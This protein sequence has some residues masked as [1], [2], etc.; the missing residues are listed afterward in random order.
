MWPSNQTNALMTEHYRGKCLKQQCVWIMCSPSGTLTVYVCLALFLF[1]LSHTLCILLF[2]YPVKCTWGFVSFWVKGLVRHGS[3]WPQNGSQ[4][5]LTPVPWWMT[6]ALWRHE[7][8]PLQK[9]HQS[10]SRMWRQVK[11]GD[12]GEEEEWWEHQAKI[13]RSVCSAQGALGRL[14]TMHFSSV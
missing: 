1:F 6:Q 12:E 2:W 10:G 5:P 14:L 13:K 3:W 4:K 11:E 8:H 7:T 9:H